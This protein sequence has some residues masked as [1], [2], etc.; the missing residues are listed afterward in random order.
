MKRTAILQY[1][2]WG[3][4]AGA[5][6][7]SAAMFFSPAPAHLL[8]SWVLFCGLVSLLSRGSFIATPID[9]PVLLYVVVLTVSYLLTPEQYNG[10]LAKPPLYFLFFALTQLDLPENRR[11]EIFWAFILS[12]AVA[13]FWGFI[14]FA[15]G[16]IER[17]QV[18]GIGFTALATLLLFALAILWSWL[19][20]IPRHRVKLMIL[21]LPL[22][23]GLILS[24]CRAQWMA[25][26]AMSFI[27][28]YRRYRKLAWA[29]LMVLAGAFLALVLVPREGVEA[30]RF[31]VTDP[32]FISSRDII[33][34]GAAEAS[35]LMPATG[36]GPNS[37]QQAFPLRTRFVTPVEGVGGWHNDILQAFLEGG[38]LLLIA[39]LW[40][41]LGAIRSLLRS[42]D[43]IKDPWMLGACRGIAAATAGVAISA[44]L[45][46]VATVPMVIL[47]Q[48]MLW[49]LGLGD[50]KRFHLGF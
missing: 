19:I 20:T 38:P 40:I 29:G 30:L 13:C 42:G 16:R 12:A 27:M 15:L 44:L 7:L 14:C 28:A 36:Y 45:C 18:V 37:F 11:R 32:E 17:V 23:G 41:I 26:V 24:F 49:G 22:L 10:S 9:L 5:M 25:A 1:A 47:G 4:W 2:M 8:W 39:Y 33:Y 48:T 50:Q 6:L 21:C 3:G 43:E 46:N 35:V 31:R 34:R